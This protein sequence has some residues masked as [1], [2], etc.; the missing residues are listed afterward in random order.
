MR[1]REHTPLPKLLISVE[2]AKQKLQAQIEKG[3][4]LIEDRIITSHEQLEK[5]RRDRN[6]WSS[7]KPKFDTYEKDIGSTQNSV[8]QLKWR[9]IQLMDTKD[10]MDFF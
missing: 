1:K 6:K 3:H 8:I 2:E 10:Q 5:A 9:L 7:F 4:Q